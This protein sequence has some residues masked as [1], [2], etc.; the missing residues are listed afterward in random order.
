MPDGAW[1]IAI[2]NLGE[3]LRRA[4]GSA[5]P[6]LR[7]SAF[8]VYILHQAAI[9]VPGYFLIQLPLGIA[10]KFLLVLSVAVLSALAAYHF[11]VRRWEPVAFLF[12]A[13]VRRT[14]PRVAVATAAAML[15][16]WVLVVPSA[17]GSAVSGTPLGRWYAEGGAAQVEIRTCDNQFCGRVVWLRSPWDEFGC[18]LRDRYNPDATLRDRS[19]LGLDI[20]SGLSGSRDED[21]VW[22]GG[23]IYDPAS[24]RT[25][26]CQAELDGPDQLEL[27]GY[28][29]IP[30]LGRTTRWFRVGAE[31]RMCR[32]AQTTANTA[33]EKHP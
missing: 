2:L 26:S 20:L 8:P 11:V 15:V 25:Y 14:P 5:L 24:G 18:E 28:F 4:W 31:E 7:D 1:N 23:A 29:G 32:T 21:G 12:G 16:L 19:V 27:R 10:A 6:Y 13:H 9:V 3:R 33:Q 22:R 30:L 17:R